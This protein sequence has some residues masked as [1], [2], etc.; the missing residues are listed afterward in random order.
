MDE[1]SN[2]NKPKQI[3]KLKKQ[4]QNKTNPQKRSGIMLPI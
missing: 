4:Q 3:Y 2:K 1:F